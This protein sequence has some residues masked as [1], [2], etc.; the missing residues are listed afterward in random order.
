VR[1]LVVYCHPCPDSFTAA[2]RDTVVETL[3]NHGHTVDVLDLYGQSFDPRL[4]SAEHAAHRSRTELA[5]DVADSAARLGRCDALILVYPTWWGAQ[6]AM[7]KGWLERV[8]VHGVAL[9]LA[10]PTGRPRP[11]LT[12]IGRVVVV[13]T[14][15][16]SKWINAIQGEAGKRLARRGLRAALGWRRRVGWLALY[17]I[18]RA[19]PARRQRFLKQ[20]EG[21]FARIG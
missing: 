2:V 8:W 15:G 4:T 12:G 10:E 14:H 9:D 5:A 13:T 11:L 3:S 6:P 17:G 19:S 20:V 21:R 7:L 1:A 18:D 16:S